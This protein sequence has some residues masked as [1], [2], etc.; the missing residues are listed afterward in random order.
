MATCALAAGSTAPLVPCMRCH[1]PPRSSVG[2]RAV[3][4]AD[5]ND[6]AQFAELKTQGDL[7]R[8][9]WARDVQVPF[10]LLSAS[11]LHVRAKVQMC[12]RWWLHCAFE[13]WEGM[14]SE[15]CRTNWWTRG[16]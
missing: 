5:A 8:R 7:T 1:D 14:C 4:R 12:G 3:W 6:A 11:R 16:C 10:C 2:V 13:H 15:T 9:A